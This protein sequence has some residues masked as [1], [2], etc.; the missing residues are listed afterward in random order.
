MQAQPGGTAVPSTPR[1]IEE[2]LSHYTVKQ[3]ESDPLLKWL[4]LKVRRH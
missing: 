2:L 1:E 3:I 4:C